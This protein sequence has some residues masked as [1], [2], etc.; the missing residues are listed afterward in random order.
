MINGGTTNWSLIE[1]Q[2]NIEPRDGT[3]VAQ[4]DDSEFAILGGFDENL[5]ELGEVL[6]FDTESNKA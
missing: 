5:K 4:I 2:T 1:L 6:L 3:L